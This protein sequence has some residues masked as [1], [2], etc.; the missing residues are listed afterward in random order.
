MATIADLPQVVVIGTDNGEAVV[1]MCD[2]INRDLTSLL[3]DISN[4]PHV[5]VDPVQGTTLRSRLPKDS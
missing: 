1:M 3:V 5:P 4:E 2:A